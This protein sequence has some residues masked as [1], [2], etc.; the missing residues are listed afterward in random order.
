MKTRT[1][2]FEDFLKVATE[3][4]KTDEGCFFLECNKCKDG[5]YML[6]G[7]FDVLY[8]KYIKGCPLC[9]GTDLEVKIGHS[10]L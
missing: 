9:K 6:E 8:K 2:F 1:E 10:E 7:S 3:L 4:I 5:F